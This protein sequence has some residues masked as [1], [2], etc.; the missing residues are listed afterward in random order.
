MKRF[1]ISQQI[2]FAFSTLLLLSL[3]T[4]AWSYHDLQRIRTLD[5][6][7]LSL[8]VLQSEL[9][10]MR[11][12]EKDFLSDELISDAFYQQAY[13]PFEDSIAYHL[14]SIREGLQAL[15]FRFAE[16]ERYLALQHQIN[17]YEQHFDQLKS[18][19]LERGFK[20]YGLVG[21]LRSAIH[22]VE[23]SSYDYDRADMLMLRRHEKD[24]MLRKDVKYQ[25]KFN[26][27][28]VA[29]IKEVSQQPASAEQSAILSELAEYARL[30]NALVVLEE[31]I[32]F[33]SKL[34]KTGQLQ[35]EATA[36]EASVAGLAQVISAEVEAEK[37]FR[38]QLLLVLL[39]V[40]LGFGLWM[41]L[42]L[43]RKAS[44]LGI[45]F[46]LIRDRILSLSQGRLPESFAADKADEIG[47]TKQALNALIA[48][49]ERYAYF[50]TNI[51]EGRLEAEFNKL[52][53]E[54]QIGNALLEMRDKLSLMV[55]EEKRRSWVNEGVAQTEAMMR[56]FEDDDDFYAK[57]IA[58]MVRYLDLNQGGLFVK[59]GH[60]MVL[61]GC[62][63]WGRKK[64]RQD[65]FSLGEGLIGQVW[66]EQDTIY[67]TEVPQHFVSITSG[68]G[69]ANPTAILLVP[70]VY[71]EEVIGVIELASFR[72]LA[73]H[74]IELVEKAASSIAATLAKVKINAE[75]RRLYEQSQQ[76][77]EELRAQ[78]EEM[79]QNM[80]EL[81]AIQEEQRRKEKE[82]QRQIEE[83]QQALPQ[84]KQQ[85]IQA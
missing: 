7:R 3:L 31:R 66:Q 78:E 13:S 60:E 71:N 6:Q 37:Q 67:L 40:Q 61:K 79:R 50:A 17:R 55:S 35:K 22:A 8:E 9:W 65:S 33:N 36:V 23:K 39:V 70:L 57:I 5:E 24:F 11:N 76:Q 73:P 27:G 38:M 42:L 82:Y 34:G 20:D 46:S 54:D 41:T 84:L 63:A 53:E 10:Q 75:T 45:N 72:T 69:D 14:L 64:Y 43:S 2:K 21:Q 62:Y 16:D 29:L 19:C 44:R 56:R 30:F 1:S 47:Q 48:G 49:M 26:D 74:E 85:L 25:Q 28:L 77:A 18:L 15:G 51:G 81:L 12:F 83:L 80:E 52:S 59:E 32:G 4:A 58:E 68:L